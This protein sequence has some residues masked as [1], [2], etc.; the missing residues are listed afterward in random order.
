TSAT[1]QIAFEAVTDLFFG[2][3]RV[4]LQ[5]LI[6]GHDHA[7]RAE[8]ALQ[9][10]LVPEGFLHRVQLAIRGQPFDSGD[11]LTVRLD[12]EH[13]ARLHRLAI[14][15]DGAGAADGCFTPDVRPGEP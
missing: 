15:R 10:M 1:A 12:G 13:G 3:L 4:T 6:R 11:V 5:Q 14:E 7:R 8:A 9:A 2:G